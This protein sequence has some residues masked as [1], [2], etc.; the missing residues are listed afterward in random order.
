MELRCYSYDGGAPPMDSWPLE[1]KMGVTSRAVLHRPDQSYYT[2]VAG[3]TLGLWLSLGLDLLDTILVGQ[4]M[5]ALFKWALV[6]EAYSPI[7]VFIPV[8]SHG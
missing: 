1:E 4:D 8:E 2:I 6:Q 7:S 3:F 5:P